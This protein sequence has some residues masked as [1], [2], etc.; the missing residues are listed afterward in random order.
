M[1]MT[2]SNVL[3][4]DAA[5]AKNMRDAVYGGLYESRVLESFMCGVQQVVKVLRENIKEAA[6]R[7]ESTCNLMLMFLPHDIA[8]DSNPPIIESVNDEHELYLCHYD[9]QKL[10]DMGVDEN[11]LSRIVEQRLCCILDEAGFDVEIRSSMM[12]S[13]YIWL[14][15]GW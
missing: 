2:E 15:V 12:H 13:E 8:A 6:R 3:G 1:R 4:I 9:E 10:E 5:E 7:G 14:R 11:E